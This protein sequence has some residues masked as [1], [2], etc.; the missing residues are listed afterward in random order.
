[1][2]QKFKPCDP[3]AL[4]QVQ[5][6]Y[7]R[8]AAMKGRAFMFGQQD[9]YLLGAAF[10]P[11][12]PANLGK[13]DIHSATG[14]Y[15]GVAGFDVGHLE[16]YY[17]A[18]RDEEFA[19]LIKG[20]DRTGGDFEPGMNIDSID[21]DFMREAI[22]FAHK[23]G[24]VVTISWHS[25]NPLTGG[26]YGPPNRSWEE[27]VVKAVLPG[28]RLNRRFNLYLDAF[29]AYN[30]TL[31]DE[32]GQLIPYIF[33]P[34]HEHSGDWFWWC[35]DSTENPRDGSAWSGDNGRLNE[36]EDY[37]ALYRY[38]V[39]YLWSHGVHNLLY[40]V[41]PDRSRMPYEGEEPGFN[42]A[43]AQAWMSGYPGDGYIDLFGLDDYWDL[44]H[45]YN[46]D[47]RQPDGRPTPG[48]VQYNQFCGSIETLCRLAEEHGKLAALTEMGLANERVLTEAGRDPRAP[49]T[50][51]LLRAVQSN[52]T[53]RQLLYG[54]VWRPGFRG[55]D[56]D[57]A[58]VYRYQ[59]R[60]PE[61]LSKGFQAV[62]QYSLKE[63]MARFAE[64]PGV[65]FIED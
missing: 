65:R 6:L 62:Y 50:Q 45:N 49:Y 56:A 5:A 44:G 18:Q 43:L 58:G 61:D 55:E 19:R 38:T 64:S 2:Q 63:D 3:Q 16:V 23:A 11:N 29:V 52:E 48:Q 46:T 31:T 13:S 51:W 20:K 7:D 35:T 47:T 26:E 53:T 25:V 17:T 54:L 40:C 21:F 34:F 10:R 57:P 8:L 37:A 42:Q 12:D 60:D 33:R 15:P 9:T 36:P 24:S 28:G 32:D 39:E 27:S 41:C 22:R 59:P 1:M 30:A 14:K 4:P